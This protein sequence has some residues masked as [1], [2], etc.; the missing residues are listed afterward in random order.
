MSNMKKSTKNKLSYL[1][2]KNY[3]INIACFATSEDYLIRTIYSFLKY[4][5]YNLNI[6]LI[7]TKNTTKKIIYKSKYSNTHPYLFAKNKKIP[8][9]LSPSDDYILEYCNKKNISLIILCGYY[10]KITSIIIN[11]FKGL[12]IN[13]HP[14]L[15]PRYSGKG[16]YGLNIHKKVLENKEKYTGVT[17]HIVDEEYDSGKIISQLKINISDIIEGN[18]NNIN[19]SLK[20]LKKIIEIKEK[21]ILIKLLKRINFSNYSLISKKKVI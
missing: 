10:K 5:S 20:I 9:L 7:V 8:V 13:V 12:I 21:K 1:I 2:K 6:S 17:I 3:K 19:D 18:K 14:S 15:L 4:N 11:N 16:M